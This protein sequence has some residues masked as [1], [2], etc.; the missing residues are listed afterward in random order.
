[1]AKSKSA[2]SAV[3]A[4]VVSADAATLVPTADMNA[5]NVM[6]ANKRFQAICAKWLA[7]KEAVRIDA[8]SIGVSP[9]NRLGAPPNMRYCHADLCPNILADGFEPSRPRPG[10]LIQRSQED[11]V[12]RL[13]DHASKLAR[14]S[15]LFPPSNLSSLTYECLAANHLTLAL[16]MFKDSVTSHL[17]GVTFKIPDDDPDLDYVCKQGHLYFILKDGISDDDARFLSEYM[18]ADQNQNQFNSEV[19]LIK[20]VYDH[21]VP[22]MQN[23]AMVPLSK[24]IASV[25]ASAVAKLRADTIG[26]IAQYVMGFGNGPYI[27]E[28]VVWHAGAVNPKELSVSPKWFGDMAKALGKANPL[29]KFATT[30]VHYSGDQRIEGNRPT[31]DTSR[32]IAMTDVNGLAKDTEKLQECETFLRE[33]RNMLTDPMNKA[34]GK[35][36]CMKLIHMFEESFGRLLYS[37]APN[38]THFQ[39]TVTGKYSNEKAK[40]LRSGWMQYCELKYDALGGF[41]KQF[42][43]HV[44][45]GASGTASSGEVR[46]TRKLAN[47]HKYT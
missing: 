43:V 33:T 6:K 15:E 25:S 36:V 37:K 45:E 16:R 32:T 26:D 38:K 1:M 40:V 23:S 4:S 13:R 8:D 20:Q 29:V 28:L 39:H 11:T 21:A 42:D 34:V 9:F 24:V 18:N 35:E 19:H 14:M 3:A 31:P 27:E 5:A 17:T 10:F 7:R 30:L 44:G 47:P 46:W 22:L 12:Q 2:T 41:G